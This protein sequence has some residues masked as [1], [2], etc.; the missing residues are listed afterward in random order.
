MTIPSSIVFG[1]AALAF[2]LV[3]ASVAHAHC[4]TLSGPV[5][6]D[7]RAA[8]ADAR[9]DAVLKWI[10]PQ[11]EG[12]IRKAFE[13]TLAVRGLS[14]EAAALADRWFMEN[15]VRVHRAG[16]GAPY[17]GLQESESTSPGIE[18]ADHALT[19]GDA[20]PLLDVAAKQVAEGLMSR[21]ER[22]R[23]A[24]SHKDHNV[25]A[26]RAYVAAYVDFIHYA[27]AVLGASGA[28]ALETHAEH[29]H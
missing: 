27:E 9:P 5:V 26:G 8:I 15:L 12:E 22:V 17:V 3:S 21:F 7:A 29:Q 28:A 2:G 4:D 14:P 25:E 24:A 10:R 1:A 18:A 20:Q 11:D 23:Q 16:E 6:T 13:Q 19:S